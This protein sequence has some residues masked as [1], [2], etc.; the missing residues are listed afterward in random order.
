LFN[1]VPDEEGEIEELL[2]EN[3]MLM[4]ARTCKVCMDAEVNTVLLPCGHL[5]C[6]ASCADCAVSCPVC[7]NHISE[8]VK[9]AGT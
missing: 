8:K 2:A 1:A 5:V 9:I 4:K 6:C 3:R 7:S